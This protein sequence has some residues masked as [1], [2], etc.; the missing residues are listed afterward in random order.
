VWTTEP[1]LQFYDGAKLS[2][3]V[4]G[5]NGAPAGAH[6]G[7]CFEAQT[8]PDAPNR[9]HFPSAVVRPSASYRQVTQYR[10]G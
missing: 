3:P 9:R 6:A 2:V 4:P 8:Y 7:L 1:G 5:L 10:F